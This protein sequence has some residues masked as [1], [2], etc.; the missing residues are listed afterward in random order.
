MKKYNKPL[1]LKK[2]KYK[3]NRGFFQELF[4]RKEIKFD[5]KFTAIAHSKKN[6]IRGLHFQLKNKQTKIIY[7]VSGKI[8]DVVVNIKR[9]SKNFG[10]KYYFILNAGDMILIPNFFA[11]GYE[12]LSNSSTIVYHL[13][14]YRDSKNESGIQYN[15][16]K[17]KIKWKTRKPILSKRDKTHQSFIEFKNKHKGL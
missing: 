9:N 8:L 2:E 14:K 4:V 15:D 12:C 16:K 13:D 11:H 3:D 17:L 1:L 7:V 5:I 6:A 10:K